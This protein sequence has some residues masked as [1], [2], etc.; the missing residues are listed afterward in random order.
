MI[1]YESLPTNCGSTVK[2][3]SRIASTTRRATATAVPAVRICSIAIIAAG[4]A[5]QWPKPIPA[6]TPYLCGECGDFICASS[7]T[8]DCR[9]EAASCVGS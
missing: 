7:R 4:P 5:M 8:E 1:T 2:T 6:T 3:D 9:A